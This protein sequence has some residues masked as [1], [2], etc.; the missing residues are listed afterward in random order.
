[1]FCYELFLLQNFT[2][3]V[4]SLWPSKHYERIINIVL[5]ICTE[6]D[7][8]GLHTSSFSPWGSWKLYRL[9]K[10]AGSIERN[11][12]PSIYKNVIFHSLHYKSF[13]CGIL[14]KGLSSAKYLWFFF[15]Y[16]GFETK[17]DKSIIL[18]KH[19]ITVLDYIQIKS[20]CH[21]TNTYQILCD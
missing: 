11:E 4:D 3:A 6:N 8:Q 19:L 5:C 18:M 7:W 9:K 16:V 1:M 17:E 12:T 15:F 20:T 13:L 21:F 14:T 10:K 2:V